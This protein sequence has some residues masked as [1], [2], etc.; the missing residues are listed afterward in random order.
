MVRGIIRTRLLGKN[1]KFDNGK[2][3]NETGLDFNNA[4]SKFNNEKNNL[5]NVNVNI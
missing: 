5:N 4:N 3:N 2:F 1:I